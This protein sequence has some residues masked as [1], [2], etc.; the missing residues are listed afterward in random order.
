MLSTVRMYYNSV[1][2]IFFLSFFYTFV[3][4][5]RFSFFRII[6]LFSFF[7]F[8]ILCIILF[9][10]LF[11]R[12]FLFTILSSVISILY[13]LKNIILKFVCVLASPLFG[14]FTIGSKSMLFGQIRLIIYGIIRY[15]AEI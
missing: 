4:C 15:D 13:F 6:Y 7:L 1:A 14:I 9:L 11:V 8:S 2:S 12:N 3:I 5:A 10:Y